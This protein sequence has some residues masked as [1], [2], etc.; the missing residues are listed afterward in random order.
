MT[1]GWRS[2]LFAAAD[3]RARLAKIATRGADA[4]ILD[5]EDA[6]PA[7]RKATALVGLPDMIDSLAAQGCTLVVRINAGWRAAIAELPIV[8]RSDV[9]AIMV[10]KVENAADLGALRGIVAELA[11]DRGIAA[12]GIIALVESPA[13]IAELD[14]IAGV[15]GLVGLALGTEDLALSLGVAPSREALDLPCRLLAMAAARYGLMA[16]ALPVS[17]ATIEDEAAWREGVRA[18]RAVGSTGALCI[19]PRQVEPANAGFSPS[20]VEVDQARRILDAWEGAEDSG[21]MQHEGKMIDLPVV[22]AAQRLLSR[23]R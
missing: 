4:V 13:G 6:I 10:P 14:R 21:V 2:L 3:D 23:A 19:H 7:K 17:I 5:L 22:L 12:P 11:E 1:L 8:V 20:P 18:G 15:S 16:I 9:A